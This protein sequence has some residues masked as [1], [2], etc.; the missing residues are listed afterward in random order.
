MR[1]KC[2]CRVYH[3]FLVLSFSLRTDT[4]LTK[5]SCGR[6]DD[7]TAMAVEPA[8]KVARA[9]KRRRIQASVGQ[10]CAHKA[11][12]HELDENGTV[13]GPLDVEEDDQ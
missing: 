5:F 2:T 9:A 12:N 8:R 13:G 4:K 1:S 11:E 7:P 3:S 6:Y 10:V